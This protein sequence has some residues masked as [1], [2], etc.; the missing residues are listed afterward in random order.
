MKNII[1]KAISIVLQYHADQF[2]K[3]NILIPAATHPLYTGMLISYYTSNEAYI[4]AAIL[5]DTLEDTEY[6]LEQLQRDFGDT[7]AEYVSV[8]SENKMIFDW[9]TRKNEYI[10][11][12]L[13]NREAYSIKVFDCL[14]NMLELYD[15]LKKH[16]NS[17]WDKFNAPKA[18][19]H[20]YFNVVLKD[21][22]EMMPKE[23][24]KKYAEL[25]KDLEYFVD[26]NQVIA[27]L[28]DK[29]SEK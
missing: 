25:L 13:K 15:E 26:N 28:P 12:M 17:F 24:I 27:L 21:N 23:I 3:G 19:K 16:G 1:Q 6:T 8:L 9:V 20:Q 14:A 7:I 10:D 22:M 2:R 5:H 11:R 18:L 29:G 4:A